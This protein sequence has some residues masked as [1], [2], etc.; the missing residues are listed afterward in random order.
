[1]QLECGEAN[2]E[3]CAKDSRKSET[4][5]V[6]RRLSIDHQGEGT[7]G[8]RKSTLQSPEAAGWEQPTGIW[9]KP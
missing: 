1:M 6:K 5:R 4:V 3:V 2:T 9:L 8:R 7:K